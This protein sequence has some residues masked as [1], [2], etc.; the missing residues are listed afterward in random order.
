MSSYSRRARN[1]QNDQAY[2]ND[3]PPQSDQANQNDQPPQRDR[4]RITIQSRL[5][6]KMHSACRR[7]GMPKF[8]RGL[9]FYKEEASVFNEENPS[10]AKRYKRPRLGNAF[11]LTDDQFERIVQILA[12]N[13]QSNTSFIG[14]G[15]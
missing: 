7:A 8:V 11:I 6:R 2:Q 10:M 3:Q 5:L 12:E 13:T 15:L 4:R 9:V 1:A 14:T